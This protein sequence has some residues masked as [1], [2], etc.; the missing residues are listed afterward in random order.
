MQKNIDFLVRKTTT[1][2]RNIRYQTTRRRLE[3]QFG[4]MHVPKC[5]GTMLMADIEAF[6]RPLQRVE[7]WDLSQTAGTIP[8]G[9]K[10]RVGNQEGQR[11]GGIYISPWEI[12]IKGDM[13]AGHFARSTLQMRFPDIEIMSIFRE[14][15]TRLLS[16]WFYL[17]DYS[18]RTLKSFGSWG[19][20]MA[21]ARQPLR[22]FIS[23]PSIAC[24]TDNVIT[25][26]LLWPH[27]DIPDSSFIDPSADERLIS[28]ALLRLR[29]ISFVDVIENEDM[30]PRL[31]SWLRENW[32]QT[33]WSRIERKLNGRLPSNRN[34]A[35][36]PLFGERYT[37]A[38]ELSG[39]TPQILNSRSRLD[40]LLWRSVAKSCA[41]GDRILSHEDAYLDLACERYDRLIRESR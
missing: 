39:D 15:K 25:R 22:S 33:V 7:G 37:M 5:G 28:E 10:H 27:V 29:D 6:L 8:L 4:F 26:L 41:S 38:Q 23:S 3:P 16:H 34:A 31:F 20:H 13:I 9:V 12:S 19:D 32:G 21:L 2:G 14:P 18:D 40:A 35:R 17:R 11:V 30:R 24:L 1:V 36:P